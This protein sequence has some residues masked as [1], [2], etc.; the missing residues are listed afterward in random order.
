MMTLA[1]KHTHMYDQWKTIWTLLLEKDA[2]N[3]Q[4]GWLQTIHLYKADYNLM[5]KWFSSQGFIVRS[6]HAHHIANNQGGSRPGRCAIDLVITKVLSYEIAD[7]MQ[8]CIIVVVND[9]TASF[10]WMIESH[11]NLAC[12]QHGADP[13]YIQL[14]AQTQKELCYHL[15][16]K[17]GISKGFNTNSN[18]NPWHGMGQGAG[19]ACSQWIIGSDSMANTY[20]TT[21]HGWVFPSPTLHD[22]IKQTMKAFIDNVNLFIG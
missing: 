1:I 12:L 5:L 3:P 7:T 4:I 20:S 15:K 10:N 11:N 22:N 17:Y 2:G 19:D 9:M 13:K 21:A 16:D 14:H 18:T 8:M 6:K